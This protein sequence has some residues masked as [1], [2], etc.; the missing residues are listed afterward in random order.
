ME[1]RQV[2]IDP[3][4]RI[5]MELETATLYGEPTGGA[6]LRFYRGAVPLDMDGAAQALL[7]FYR[8]GEQAETKP[9]GPSRSQPAYDFR[10]DADALYVSFHEAYHIDLADV[11]LHWWKFRK[12]MFGLPGG[13]PFGQRVHY[14]LADAAGMSKAEKKQ[15]AKMKER[16]ALKQPGQK[17]MT[18]EERDAW[19]KDYADRKF[20][21]YENRK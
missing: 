15:Y 13:T 7:W 10:Q 11:R 16:Y 2:P 9:D 1:G 20:A 3:D 18:L 17:R 6:F 21:A 8:C 4:F 5:M 19:M 14:R 12:L